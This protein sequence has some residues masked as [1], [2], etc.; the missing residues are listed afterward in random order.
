[1]LKTKHFP[2]VNHP[3]MSAGDKEEMGR[4]LLTGIARNV[5]EGLGTVSDEWNKIFPEYRFT[6]AEEFLTGVFKKA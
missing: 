5:A 2:Q 3:S 1:M 6:T 4:Q